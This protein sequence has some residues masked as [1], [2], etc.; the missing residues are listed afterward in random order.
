MK[1]LHLII[2]APNKHFMLYQLEPPEED[3]AN[4]EENVLP[5]L[6][7]QVLQHHLSYNGMHGTSGPSTIQV[8]AQI[9]GL[10][11][12]ALID[13]GSSDSFIQPRIAKFLN[14]PVQPVPGF[15]VMVGNFDIMVVEG[16]IPSLEICLQGYKEQIPKVYMLHVAGGNLV[17]GNTWLKQLKTHIVD[18]ESSFIRFLHKGHFVTIYGDKTTVPRQAQFHHIKRL[19]N[20]DHIAEAFTIQMHKEEDVVKHVLPLLADMEPEL[21]LLLHTYAKVFEQPSGLPPQREHD[22]SIPLVQGAVPVKVRSY[23]YPHSRKAH[24]ELMV[25]QMLGEGIIQASKNPFSSPILLVKK[26]DGTW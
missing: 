24:I 15:K 25:N 10:D 2:A 18:Y 26:K 21:V 23:R 20:M 8:K 16:C 1:S 12:Q 14:L 9:N 22:H 6:E 17:I 5:Q 7:H 19:M 11:I 3:E 13:G 4:L